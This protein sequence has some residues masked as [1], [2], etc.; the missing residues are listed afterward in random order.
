MSLIIRSWILTTVIVSAFR[1]HFP[2]NVHK[3]FTTSLNGV[4]GDGQ[5][6]VED[7]IDISFS[8]P[9]W[10]MICYDADDGI[11]GLDTMDPKLGV[12]I[13]KVTI[14]REGGLGL[15]L[16]EFKRS[17]DGRNMVL[18]ES[19]TS[20]GNAANCGLIKVGDTICSVGVEPFMER[21]EGLGL[22]DTLDVIRN[23]SPGS[24]QLTLVLKR[25]VKRKTLKVTFVNNNGDESSYTMLAGSNLRGEMF[26]K[27]IQVYDTRTKRFDQPYI[28]GDCGGEG[29]CGTCLVECQFGS[30][31][32][33]K[34]EGVE[35]MVTKKRPYNWRLSC[36]TIIGANNKSGDIKFRILPQRRW[37]DNEQ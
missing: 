16:I 11:F 34:R 3:P 10:K 31:F 25:L 29:L 26:K 14:P 15:D 32:L 17:N 13:V 21:T 5:P 8:A 19:L 35:E 27:D 23:A 1:I 33:N 28:T 22:D 37:N 4:S 30:E 20:G 36:K 6:I 9:R 12:E 2:R 24:Q 7:D 18:I